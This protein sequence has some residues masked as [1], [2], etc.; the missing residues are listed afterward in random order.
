MSKSCKRRHLIELILIFLLL[1]PYLSYSRADSRYIKT[2]TQSNG[3]QLQITLSSYPKTLF[4]N[5]KYTYKINF[6]V[7]AV[8]SYLDSFYSIAVGLRFLSSEKTVKSDLKCDIGDLP[9]IGSKVHVLI[10]L[11]VPSATE[12][13]INQGESLQGQLQYIVYYSKQPKDWDKSEMAP[14]QW[15]H[16][17]DQ[18]LGWETISEAVIVNPLVDL[19]LLTVIVVISIS[20]IISSII[21]FRILKKR[22]QN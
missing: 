13:S 19:F 10:Q 15:P 4:V 11:S 3:S 2:W 1:T 9:T 20:L 14:N 8:S 18:T 17:S 21:I 5:I 12:I 16:E 6:E 22:S 7:K